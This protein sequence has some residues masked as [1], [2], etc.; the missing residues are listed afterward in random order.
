[1]DTTIILY[2]VFSYLF[3][4]WYWKVEVF[5]VQETAMKAFIIAISIIVAPLSLISLI[6]F[7]IFVTLKGK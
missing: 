2:C 5:E 6:I 3:M 4:W 1:M 7:K